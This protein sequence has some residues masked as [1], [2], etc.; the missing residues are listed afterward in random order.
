MVSYTITLS[1]PNP[2]FKVMVNILKTAHLT[3]KVTI[4]H[5]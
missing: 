5:Q 1:D 2:D 4:A 3:D